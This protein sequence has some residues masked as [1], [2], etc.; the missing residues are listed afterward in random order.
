LLEAWRAGDGGAGEL[1]FER[2]YPAVARFFANKVATDPADL[3]QETFM[4]LLQGRD[5]IRDN[6]HFRSYVFGIAYNTLRSHYRARHVDGERLDFGSTSSADLA[7]G[8][9][10][11]MASGDEQALLLAA[12]RRIPI[13]LQVV[14]ELFYWE[15]MTSAEI[16]DM[17][18]EPHG[19]V[20][21]RIRR[22][23]ELARLA[24]EDLAGDA[25]V[26]RRTAT[27]LDGW[28]AKVRDAARE[29]TAGR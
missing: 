3:L 1:L 16:A 23:R 26:R 29:Q 13:E 8:V 20:R 25:A 7:P 27:D 12:L 19:T 22:A 4:A 15:D 18:G 9:G 21:T 14:L 24:L 6:A 17:L 11:M 5:R 28:A 2:Y 10:T